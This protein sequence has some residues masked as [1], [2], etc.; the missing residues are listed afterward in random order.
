M[1][2]FRSHG[3]V[4]EVDEEVRRA[5]VAVVLRDLVLED[6]MVAKR[7]PGQLRDEAMILVQ[8][9]APVREDQVRGD[10][11]LEA[12]EV[13]LDLGA[14]VREEAVAERLGHDRAALATPSRNASALARASAARVAG[15]R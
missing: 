1:S 8:I 2:I 6:Q 7:V 5:Q 12:L 15:C 11:A 9:A 3:L 10:L 4:V 14:V 13:L